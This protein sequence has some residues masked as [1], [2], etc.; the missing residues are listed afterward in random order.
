M[1]P[2]RPWA[3]AL[4]TTMLVAACA[5]DGPDRTPLPT[6][7]SAALS[8]VP[9]S[10]SFPTMKNAAKAWFRA[11]ND[12]VYTQISTM[13]SAYRS[14]AAAA[15]GPGFDVLARVQQAVG[16][17]TLVKGSHGRLTDRPE[18]GPLFITTQPELLRDR[19]GAIAATD[20]KQLVLDHVFE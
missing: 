15:T 16:N 9:A 20:F 1:R 8:P 17:A 11:N 14:G 10:C 7:V 3:M 5:P 2:N 19:Q 13:Q 6:S 4:A 12:I 18:Q